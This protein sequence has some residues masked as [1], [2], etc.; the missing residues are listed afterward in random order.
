MDY[1]Q[2]DYYSLF[3]KSSF[4]P[5][6]DAVE[7]IP[8][9][10][11][12]EVFNNID[13]R[14]SSL[15]SNPSHLRSDVCV[16]HLVGTKLPRPPPFAMD[17]ERKKA[18]ATA[19]PAPAERDCKRPF[20]ASMECETP[21]SVDT[22]LPLPSSDADANPL[23]KTYA[24][25]EITSSTN[26]SRL[27][28][29]TPSQ[30]S[31]RVSAPSQVMRG[32]IDLKVPPQE[33][34]TR[35]IM[36]RRR[37]VQILVPPQEAPSRDKGSPLVPSDY[38]G[39][40][41]SSRSSSARRS[42]GSDCA[43]LP[44]AT[45]VSGTVASSHA[46]M[47]TPLARD[48]RKRSFS[49]KSVDSQASHI[50]SVPFSEEDATSTYTSSPALARGYK[51]GS[52][53]PQT[54]LQASRIMS[55]PFLE[56]DATSTYTSSPALA[57]GYKRE[58]CSPQASIDTASPSMSD[59]KGAVRSS[60][61]SSANNPGS[62]CAS[63]PGAKH[64]SGP[65]VSSHADMSSPLTRDYK[66]SF[67]AKSVGSKASRIMSVPFLEEDATSTY[68]SSPAPARGYKRGS[69]S[70][71]A[72]ID[73]ASSSTSDYKGAVRSS[74]SSSASNP[75]SA[76]ASLPGA[77]HV[78]RPVVPIYPDMSSPPLA[79]E[80]KMSFSAKKSVGSQASRIM[81][82]PF[83]DDTGTY[84]SSPAMA[85]S[86]KRGSPLTS[87]QARSRVLPSATMAVPFTAEDFDMGISPLTIGDYKR[88]FN[89]RSAVVSPVLPDGAMA[90][91]FA[92]EDM[93]MSSPVARDYKATSFSS[94]S[95]RSSMRSMSSGDTSI[96]CTSPSQQ[97]STLHASGSLASS[98]SQA[99]VFHASCSLV[100]ASS[101]ASTLQGTTSSSSLAS[102]NN[103]QARCL[104]ASA[105]GGAS[106]LPAA[107]PFPDAVTNNPQSRP[108][109]LRWPSGTPPVTRN[110]AHRAS[111][112][113]ARPSKKNI[114][115]Q[116][117][118]T[119]V[120][121]DSRISPLVSEYD[122]SSFRAGPSVLNGTPPVPRE[123][124]QRA[125][126]TVLPSPLHR[127]Y[128][129]EISVRSTMNSTGE[130]P[131]LSASFSMPPPTTTQRPAP[132]RRRTRSI[133]I[134]PGAVLPF[135]AGVRRRLRGDQN[136][137]DP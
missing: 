20:T 9:P 98:P 76:C 70:P 137:P 134:T 120:M 39:A 5:C 82:V 41:C 4:Y 46:G 14:L 72:S 127:D 123:V 56:E 62:V 7:A 99:S 27:A 59:Y 25:L 60:R 87:S 94:H 31:K 84:P 92:A 24:N 136:G 101:H 83:S 10:D 15:P 132:S 51:R 68:T 17:C 118:A 40:F 22:A 29:P 58:S 66:M 91:P 128:D 121:S 48:Y 107:I 6:I 74:R 122:V 111:S 90:V 86:Y 115:K 97:A 104:L 34:Q 79:R 3:R 45:F 35:D 64:V 37:N 78:S 65:A 49:A 8:I 38:K 126:S 133:E 55:V 108:Q 63:L 93:D 114:Q 81:S 52:F 67:S 129:R 28:E 131:S 11:I 89:S 95:H 80:Y 12:N 106:R 30:L 2:G 73:T 71:K 57:R 32:R 61:S 69:F 43:S 85:R 100:S 13:K 44:G 26:S 117:P 135:L 1:R 23:V 110:V 116:T 119:R 77:K 88:S 16:R 36:V 53:S 113:C 103:S 125:T 112:I 124:Q 50:M 96:S 102:T 18:A 54:G 109:R 42:P 130:L 75:G 33:A 105:S 21:N 19:S 47:I